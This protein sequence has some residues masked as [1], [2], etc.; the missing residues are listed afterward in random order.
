VRPTQRWL[1][2]AVFALGCDDAPPAAQPDASLSPPG[3][4]SAVD[5][6]ARYASMCASCHGEAG[7]GG[8]GTRLVD[9]PR[10]IAE[11]TRAI[12]E[13]MPQGNAAACRG[14]CAS[15]LAN[16]I[17]AN[18]TSRALA[19]ETVPPGPRRVRLLNRR[20]YRNTVRDLFGLGGA[21]TPAPAMADCNRRRFAYDPGGRTLRSVHLAG[22]FNGWSPTAWPMTRDATSGEWSVEQ[23]LPNGSHQYKFVLDGSEWIRDPRNT[24]TASDGFGGQN[25]VITVA[26]DAPVTP[27]TTRPTLAFDP[28]A[29]FPVEARPQGFLFDDNADAALVTSVYVNE[30]LRA[31]GSIVDALAPR[32]R[33]I[34]GCDGADLPTCAD[35]VT[36]GFA[37]RAF[38]RAL[39]SAEAQRYRALITGARDVDQGV[40]RA[41]RAMLV[42]P[43]FLY[44][45]EMGEAQ[46]DGSF[47]L[48]PYEVAS[49]LSYTYWGTMPDDALLDA[50]GRG[51][52]SDNASIEREARR[53]LADARAREQVETFAAQWLGVES[54]ATTPRSASL[55]PDLSDAVRAAMI[56]ES[57]RLVSHVV[58]DGTHRFS[59]LF[60]ATEGFV[61]EPL[62]RFYGMTGVTGND[63]RRVALPAE[64][65]GGVLA[66]GAVMT[67]YA[68]SDQASPILRGVFVRVNLLCQEFP[69]PPANAGG[70]PDVDPTATTRQRFA[71]HTRNAACSSCHARIDGI[72]FGFEQFDAVGRTRTMEAGQPV[73]H[74]GRLTDVEGFGSGGAV[75]FAT[76][77]E[78]GAALAASP[79]AQ[80]CFARQWFRFA[81]GFRETAAHRCAVRAAA[82]RLQAS[83]GD[84]RELMVA[85]SLS[86]DFL[87][88]R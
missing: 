42:S 50:A 88:R 83:D 35:R 16:Y 22:T 8:L 79:T 28:A 37:R 4:T 67:R 66:Q 86:P 75:D 2:L 73:D 69:P 11:L 47:K 77:A 57:R 33:T 38:R 58:F 62:A 76:P 10:S 24:M 74:S 46:P 60:T 6:A 64:R 44:R 65:R 87:N 34:V 49:A 23:N 5:P 63:L 21:T 53:L 13:R 39:T 20:E 9:T 82:Q 12:D 32:L 59:E 48:T 56:D 52:L 55:F 54:V 36:S 41:V 7:E 18:F 85:V 1:A 19:C 78:L 45:S 71:Q 80:A 3:V 61:N 43:S 15:S 17:K 30:Q 27:P 40:R 70:V 84:L 31:A 72:G 51:G 81:R 68:H 25:S 14:E 29:T 26:C